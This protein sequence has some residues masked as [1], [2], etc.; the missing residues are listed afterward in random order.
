MNEAFDYLLNKNAELKETIQR[1]KIKEGLTKGNIKQR[2]SSCG[3]TRPTSPP[4]APK[5]Y[6]IERD[7]L[8]KYKEEQ[9]ENVS[10][11]HRNACLVQSVT[12]ERRIIDRLRIMKRIHLD[13]GEYWIWNNEEDNNLDTLLCPVVIN[14]EDLIRIAE[15]G[16]N[17]IE[18]SN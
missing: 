15:H 4:P 14:K 11:R 5:P 17:G 7:L 8:N 1:M 10:L 18:E 13:G 3:D 16:F 6:G 2:D 9:A 12:E